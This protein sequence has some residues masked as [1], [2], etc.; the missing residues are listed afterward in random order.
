[1]S[2]RPSEFRSP[3]ARLDSSR[4]TGNRSHGWKA[5]FPSPSKTKM[6]PDEQVASPHDARTIRS[7]FPSRLKSSTRTTSGFSEAQNGGSGLKV[8]SPCPMNTE[9]SFDPKLAAARSARPSLLKS[10]EAT[11]EVDFPA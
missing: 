7:W 8:P 4:A 2:S 9:M 1:M 6:R 11:H 3:S 10:P 5:P